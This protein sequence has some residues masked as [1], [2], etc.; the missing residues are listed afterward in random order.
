LESA[1]EPTR[2]D[3]AAPQPLSLEDRAKR[4]A[5]GQRAT[6][7]RGEGRFLRR[8]NEQERLLR[9]A[10][11]R[12]AGMPDSKL[13][14]SYA[15]EWLLDNFY[16]V[17][18]AI[19]QVRQDLPEG[20][21]RDLPKLDEA[22]LRDLPRIYGL[23]RELTACC[24]YYL[25][26]DR[27]RR[28][29]A[30]YQTVTPLTMGELWALPTMLRLATLELLAQAVTSLLDHTEGGVTPSSAESQAQEKLEQSAVANSILSLRTLDIEDWKALFEDLNLVEA[31]LRRDPA[32][33]YA[34]MDFET[35]DRYRKV[36]EQ[37]ARAADRSEEAVAQVALDLARYQNEVRMARGGESA[38]SPEEDPPGPP[39]SRPERKPSALHP[40]RPRGSDAQI[41]G[42][43]AARGHHVGFYL[44][45]QGWRELEAHLDYHPPATTRVRRWLEGHAIWV[46]LGSIG[47]L[48]L[49]LEIGVGGFTAESGGALLQVGAASLLAFVPAMTISVSLVHS[50]IPRLVPPR[51]LPKMEFQEGIPRECSTLVAIPALLTSPQE[52]DAL[53]RQLEQHFLS[54][55]D[56]NLHFALLTDF[57]DA[58]QK[59]MPGDE[60]LLARARE[61]IRALNQKYAHGQRARFQM[62]HRARTWN[63]QEGVWMGWERKRGKLV[64]LSGLMRGGGK[65]SYIVGGFG[66]LPHVRYVIT[67]D[68][69]SKLTRGVARRLVATLAHPLNQAVFDPHSGALIGGYTLLQP[70]VRVK[71]TSVGKTILTRIFAGDRGLDLY[72]EAVSDVYQDL[73]QEGTYV[74][75][76]IMDLAA[77][78]RSLAGRVPENALLSHDL[79]ESVVGRAGLVS[80]VTLLEDFPDQYLAYEERMHR[81]I[82]GDWQLLPWLLAQVPLEAGGGIP[83]Y[84]SALDRWKIFDNLRRSLLAPS[85]LALLVAGWV[86]LPGPAAVW[87]GLAIL[88]PAASLLAGIALEI[89][90]RRSAVPSLQVLRPLGADLLRWSFALIFLPFEAMIAVD[91]IGV[92]LIRLVLT[93]RRLLQWTSSAH[94]ARSFGRREG[95]ALTWRRMVLAPVLALGLGLLTTWLK[96]SSLPLAL[97]FL[98]AWLASPQIARVIGGHTRQPQPRLSSAERQ[99]LRVLARRTWLFY[100]RFVGPE[101]H[102]LPPDHFQESPHSQVAHRTSPTNI[103]FLLLSDLAAGDLG[104]VSPIGLA[105]R[106]DSTF[107]TLDSL[108]RHRGHFFNWY[109]TRTLAPLA[110]RYVSTVDSGNLAASLITVSQACSAMAEALVFPW[111]RW[112]GLLD[113]LALLGEGLQKA[114]DDGAATAV[115][116]ELADMAGRVLAV[117]GE[118]VQWA[119]LLEDLSGPEP[120]K[121]DRL[122]VQMIEVTP[123]T[124]SPEE[125][126]GLRLCS[127]RVRHHFRSMRRDLDVL[128][129]WVSVL[130]AP[131]ALFTAAQVDPLLQSSWGTLLKSFPATVRLREV[132]EICRAGE[133]GLKALQAQSE[134]IARHGLVAQEVKGLLPEA[135]DWCERLASALQ[136]SR[137][138]AESLI[139]QYQKLGAR[140]EAFVQAMNF[141]FLFDLRRQV[142]HIGY[143]LAAGKLDENHYDLLASEARL[144]SVVAIAKGDVPLSHWLHLGRPFTRV[145]GS[146]ALLSWNGTLFEY[147]MPPLLLGSYPGTLLD[148]SSRAAVRGQIDYARRRQ[149]PWGISES[150]YYA[151]DAGLN[152]QYRAFGV[153]GFGLKRGLDED[154]VVAPY[155]SLMALSLFPR[156]VLHNIR[157]LRRLGMVGQFGFYEAV[158]FTVSRLPLGQAQAR[159]LSYMSHHHGMTL[160]ALANFLSD[161]V[162]VRQFCADPRIQSVE[163]LQQ[164][165]LPLRAPLEEAPGLAAM[166]AQT[167]R[168]QVSLAPWGVPAQAQTPNVHLLSNGRYGVV[169]TSAGAGYSQWQGMALT[170]WRADPTLDDWGT[171]IYLKDRDSGALWSAA[172]QP[173]ASASAR[174]SA[175]FY[176]YKAEFHREQDA[177]ALKME[178]GVAVDDDVEIRHLVLTNNSDRPR[179]VTLTS[180]AEVVLAPQEVDRS[181]PAFNKLFIESE[182]LPDLGAQI[183]HRRPRSAE[184]P[185]IHLI[186]M[187]VA[188]SGQRA[189]VAHEADRARFLGRG[190]TVR[191]PLSLTGPGAGLSGTTGATLDPIMALGL[192]IELAPRAATRLAFITLASQTRAEALALAERYQ[193]LA[194]VDSAF[195][196]ARRQIEGEMRGQGLSA[197]DLAGLDQ[198]LSALLYPNPG[199]RAIVET[200]AS[201][202]KGQDGLWAFGISGDYPIL[203]VRLDSE[204][205][206]PLV[207]EVLRDHAFWRRR[208]MKIDLVLLID[209][210]TGYGQELQGELYQLLVRMQSDTWL[211]ERGGIFLVSSD[212]MGAEDRALLES[213]ARVVLDGSRGGLLEQLSKPIEAPRRLPAF[214]PTLPGTEELEPTAEIV[215]P[216]GLQFDNGRGGLTPDGSEYQIYLRPG[217]RTPSP[218]INVVANPQLGFLV[219]EAGSGYTWAENSSENRLTPWANDPVSDTPG[220]ALYLRDEE[221][222]GLWSPTPLPT[223]AAAPYL[224][225]HGAGY[226]IFEHHSHGLKQRLRLFV[227]PDAPVKV[228]ALS[229]ENLWHR[230]RRLTATYYARWVLATDPEVSSQYLVPEYE[231]QA[232]MLL[233]RN[234]YSLEFAGRFAFLAASQPPHGLT[235]DRSEFLGP[236]G[237]VGRPAALT[238]VGLAGAVQPGLDPCAAIQVH[239]EL[240]PGEVKEIFFLIGQAADREEAVRL[241][242]QLEDP[243]QVEIAWR[244]TLALWDDVLGAVQVTTPDPAMDLMLNRWLVYQVLSCRM[245]GRSALHQSSGAFGFR[246]QLQ[247]VMALVHA[248]PQI[249]RNH[250][251]EAARHQF[252]QGDVLHWWHPPSGRGV[253]TRCSDDRLWLPFVTAHYVEATGDKT[254]LAEKV[255]FLKGAALGAE[256]TDRYGLFPST[257]EEY[258]LY[259]HCRRALEKGSGCGAH[260]L[261]LIGSGD[262]N[263]GLNRVGFKGK[264]ESIWLG[265]FLQA[266]LRQF[267]ALSEGM[268][269]AEEA[270]GYRKRAE[271]L[272]SA[273]ESAGWDGNWY[274]RAYFDDGEPL[275]SAENEEW[276]IDA[277]AQ[278]WA[279]LSGAGDPARAERAMRVVRERLVHP[280]DKLVLLAAPPFDK[281]PLDPGY[282]KGYPPGVREN[283]GAYQHAALWTAWAFLELGWAEEAHA[284]FQILNPLNVTETAGGVER[285]QVEPY[286][287]AAD[288]SNQVSRAG[289][290]G[291]TW[292]TGSAG[293]MYRLGLEGI[294]GAHR[295]GNSLELAPC[296]PSAWPGYEIRYRYGRSLYHI[297][298][299]NPQ[300]VSRGVREIRLDGEVLRERRI[301]LQD[302]G[303]SHEVILLMG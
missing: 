241:A 80:D 42:L 276:S 138:A 63:P 185:P 118:P 298:V 55:L 46:Y 27:I 250:L 62:F 26:P 301:P 22:P 289:R 222:A 40:R 175:L 66:R 274:R 299:R 256:E 123:Q 82:R 8:L 89:G 195:G 65:S 182:F 218:W 302:D 192:E 288:V 238:R 287:V 124:L 201:N 115:R 196:R 5:A 277:M 187:L 148:Q 278:S 132:P 72:T 23:A 231:P 233:A 78:Q 181:H 96:S 204:K 163:L 139:L 109:D 208:G 9:R 257:D 108:E 76:G 220:E 286:V 168:Q 264:G 198:L 104:Y 293:W 131:P 228:V 265:W 99:Q 103:G 259:E 120:S 253:R 85:M 15:G 73:F 61:G 282:I 16:I 79:L 190:R 38:P 127:E 270:A 33:V 165:Q 133:A 6:R 160:A 93:R 225:R 121:L 166:S 255:P 43:F 32:Q 71:P 223:P 215:R 50:L 191:S 252:E 239:V 51:L 193:T 258:S 36:V 205:E 83:N 86:W 170:R 266:T 154:L 81:W 240:K 18:Q 235:T 56:A 30:A 98:L 214:T 184:D 213:A 135:A 3:S 84:L 141:G 49:L 162:M 117:E 262:W 58:P 216:S 39:P 243:A 155:A 59:R 229:L 136:A 164:E 17:A 88:A 169:I 245:W 284:C 167:M 34:R 140:A 100:E 172:F 47:L 179:R 295:V 77:F 158:D 153:P 254:V 221:T 113:T 188:N 57:G 137:L 31:I 67:L 183:F 14:L 236:L 280:E 232:N 35:R 12:L 10:H 171:W 151:F 112:Q 144:A 150:G 147:L 28:F 13:G 209:K 291:W 173:I 1:P 157:R 45:D 244:D 90:N 97:P 230:Q 130:R 242:Q 70:R 7:R 210:E 11:A 268:G 237:S 226:S 91:A 283:G 161:E 271:Q 246:D 68:A 92:T 279:V 134:G 174:Q 54:T 111:Q 107:D 200:L 202:R 105:L 29:V 296:I 149:I 41:R 248:R 251:L 143:N 20:F 261:P 126:N 178:V 159:V 217:E 146:L 116:D 194:A 142:L 21:Y 69:D 176:P 53:L 125:L 87:T 106:L 281:T 247:D 224:V 219:S 110:P 275:G 177:L 273:L 129:P 206:T 197:A 2:S 227:V 272:R 234:P 292:Y 64:E 122:L 95:S 199:R 114:G 101:D 249:A 152:Y 303:R 300:G 75:K 207:Q 285:Y 94:I 189:S 186:H 24:E 297:E 156:E 294:L 52:V 4:L 212:K 48:A 25:D 44:I 19:R 37:M 269:Q 74:G 128:L 102:W 119:R 260:G 145:D 290:G 263:D 267:A 203:M 211:N 180:Y 60:A